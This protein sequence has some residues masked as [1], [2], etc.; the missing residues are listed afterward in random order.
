MWEQLREGP[1]TGCHCSPR[2]AA[3]ATPLLTPSPA[4]DPMKVNLGIPR[5]DIDIAHPEPDAHRVLR[6]EPV[7]EVAQPEATMDG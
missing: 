6:A 3:P 7:V 5:Q 4:T 1:G 2:A